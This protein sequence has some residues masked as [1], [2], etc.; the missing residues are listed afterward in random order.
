MKGDDNE[1]DG[2]HGVKHLFDLMNKYF[3]IVIPPSS[4]F[5]STNSFIISKMQLIIK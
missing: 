2:K 3:Q 1:D 5:V 4:K